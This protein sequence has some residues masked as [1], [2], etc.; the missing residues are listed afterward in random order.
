MVIRPVGRLQKT[1]K[2][3]EELLIY[4]RSVLQTFKEKNTRR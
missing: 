1:K 4:K 3:K 2:I